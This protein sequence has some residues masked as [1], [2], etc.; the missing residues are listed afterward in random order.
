VSVILLN[1]PVIIYKHTTAQRYANRL[2][3]CFGTGLPQSKIHF[4]INGCKITPKR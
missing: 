1:L 2:F 3:I 4:T